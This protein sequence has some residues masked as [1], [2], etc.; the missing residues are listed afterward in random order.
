MKHVRAVLGIG[1]ILAGLPQVL[2]ADYTYCPQFLERNLG[3]LSVGL[4]VKELQLF[5]NSNRSTLVASSGIAS[6]GQETEKFGYA[7]QDA[8]KRFQTIFGLTVTGKVGLAERL[9]IKLLCKDIGQAKTYAENETTYKTTHT[10]EANQELLISTSS[11]ML[12]WQTVS[13]TSSVQNTGLRS[14]SAVPMSTNV[15]AGYDLLEG[16]ILQLTA[17]VDSPEYTQLALDTLRRI[18][19]YVQD[20]YLTRL[21]ITNT[22]PPE[23]PNLLA[24]VT[25]IENDRFVLTIYKDNYL[26]EPEDEKALTIAHELSH[27]VAMNQ[28]QHT[29]ATT[30]CNTYVDINNNCYTSD[31]ALYTFYRTFWNGLSGK[32]IFADSKYTTPYAAESASEDFAE[33]FAYFTL[34]EIYSFSQLSATRIIQS[35]TVQRKLDFF[36]QFS[37]FVKLKSLTLAGILR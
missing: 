21:V 28:T 20:K 9:T 5:L 16:G 37:E 1:M 35:P 2:F 3:M 29:E 23:T 14:V 4:D 26:S 24:A 32:Q 12:V 17:G 8:V 31:S 15:L 30:T 7:T 6:P 11:Q 34:K 25:P 22:A 10:V 27:I 13:S 18:P 19:Q 33:S 36:N